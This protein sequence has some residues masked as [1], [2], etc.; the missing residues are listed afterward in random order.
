MELAKSYLKG[1]GFR[2][3][4]REGRRELGPIVTADHYVLNWSLHI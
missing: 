4:K 1:K 2:R 3:V